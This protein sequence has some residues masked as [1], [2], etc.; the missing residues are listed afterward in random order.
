MRM[1]QSFAFIVGHQELDTDQRH[2]DSDLND[3]IAAL[4]SQLKDQWGNID[5]LHTVMSGHLA[6]TGDTGIHI[7]GIQWICM[8]GYIYRGYAAR[9]SRV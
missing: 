7:Q 3:P 8:Q 2:H 5:N 1:R 6:Y 4:A 9:C